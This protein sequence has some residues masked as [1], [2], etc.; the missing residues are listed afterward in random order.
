MPPTTSP[1]TATVWPASPALGLGF[2]PV[3]TSAIGLKPGSP[4]RFERE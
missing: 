4:A 3:D 1:T 2:E